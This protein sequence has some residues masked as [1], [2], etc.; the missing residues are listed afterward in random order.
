MAMLIEE[1]ERDPAGLPVPALASAGPGSIGP[2]DARAF[3]EPG[4]PRRA[5]FAARCVAMVLDL[6][7][8]GLVQAPL[9]R[10][11]NA[12]VTAAGAMLGRP[13]P[14][15]ADLSSI[16]AGVGGFALPAVYFVGLQAGEGR[17][18]GKEAMHLRVARP[19]GRPIGLARAA[20]RCAGYFASAIPMGLGFAAAMGPR[21]RA[22][23]DLLADTVVLQDSATETAGVRA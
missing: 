18:I 7:V 1:T 6:L 9:A 14:D 2:E 5:S 20:M 23:H 17:T 22:L 3:G 4:A 11:A 19:D 16:L 13:L 21:R 10:L 15:A 12:A 8:L